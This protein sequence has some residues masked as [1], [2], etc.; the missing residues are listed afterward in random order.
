[1]G[2]DVNVP[3]GSGRQRDCVAKNG[4][5]SLLSNDDGKTLPHSLPA[6]QR[7]IYT[8]FG[9][10]VVVGYGGFLYFR[11][12]GHAEF[13]FRPLP[14]VSVAANN[15]VAVLDAEGRIW[16]VD[17]NSLER[18][19]VSGESLSCN[20]PTWSPDGHYLGFI[21]SDGWGQD[22]IYAAPANGGP[23]T[24]VFRTDAPDLNYFNWSPDSRWL[25]YRRQSELVAKTV[26][27]PLDNPKKAYSF[28]FEHFSMWDWSD[29]SNAILWNNDGVISVHPRD[30]PKRSFQPKQYLSRFR[31]PTWSSTDGQFAYTGDVDG[32]TSIVEH[33]GESDEPRLLFKRPDRTSIVASPDFSRVAML[34]FR[35]G[36][37]GMLEILEDGNVEPTSTGRS[38]QAVYW[39][40]DSRFLAI[41]SRSIPDGDDPETV[42]HNLPNASASDRETQYLWV[43][44]LDTKK[45]KLKLKF[46][47]TE[48]SLE[49]G[50]LFS[51][52]KE[53]HSL[54]SPDSKYLLVASKM[55]GG[56]PSHIWRVALSGT[57]PP[58]DL[59]EGVFATWSSQ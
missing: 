10:L 45:D 2:I 8:L 46:I 49:M 41:W 42:S 55:P 13:D 35:P 54:W 12:D 21:A 57:A 33:V 23:L 22:G 52:Y 31:A 30:H 36:R 48:L 34:N 9:V 47:P 1:M 56:G 24:R 28:E 58:I 17:P 11:S 20:L 25:V 18:R 50:S 14:V 4:R 16:V 7:L 51:Q 5:S 27:V 3:C 53:S 59:G 32:H 19:L 43:L 6:Y 39:S 26:L 38:V 29:D 37:Y 44:D 15:Q 40:P